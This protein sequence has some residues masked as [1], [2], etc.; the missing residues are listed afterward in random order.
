MLRQEADL[1][2]QGADQTKNDAG[3]VHDEAEALQGR[4]AVTAKK[5]KEL[6]TL[7]A[8]DE[9]L[10]T[11][12]SACVPARCSL[13]SRYWSNKTHTVTSQMINIKLT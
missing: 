8:Q 3:K 7:A 5:I 4:V 13:G 2:R 1:I 10:T 9:E 12:V 11:V 6:E